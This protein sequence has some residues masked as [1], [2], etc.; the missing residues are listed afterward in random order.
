MEVLLG[1]GRTGWGGGV[2]RMARVDL[3]SFELDYALVWGEECQRNTT[4][5]P[6]NPPPPPPPKKKLPKPRE[7]VL[8][9]PKTLG[10]SESGG[11]G[12]LVPYRAIHTEP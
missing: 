2:L 5:K 6:Y 3:Q 11:P 9:K 12:V 7:K 8:A 10:S 1:G 4:K